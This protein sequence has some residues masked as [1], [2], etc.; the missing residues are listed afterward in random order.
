MDYKNYLRKNR[1]KVQKLY[2]IDT[3]EPTDKYIREF[4]VMG[5]TGNIY[6]VKIKESPECTCP[7]Y[8]TRYKR[9]KHIYFILIRI[10]KVSEKNE[11]VVKYTKVSLT[12][13]FNKNLV[14]DRSVIVDQEIKEKYDNLKEKINTVITEKE[15]K[16]T[17]DELCPICLDDLNN[18]ETL[19]HCKFSCGKS[20]HSDCFKMWTRVKEKKCLYCNHS[21]IAVPN[22]QE[23]VNLN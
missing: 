6:T 12:R 15:Q 7:D 10:M 20:V 23:Y 2:L 13:M 9:C 21:W 14:V 5:S 16:D 22:Q 3:I 8:K 1:G 11:D 4:A 19:D 17:T 18:G